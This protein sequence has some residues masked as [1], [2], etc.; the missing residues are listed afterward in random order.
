MYIVLTTL[1]YM[2]MYTC[3]AIGSCN[4]NNIPLYAPS[5]SY[6]YPG[7]ATNFVEVGQWPWWKQTLKYISACAL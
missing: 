1:A 2:Y 3:V 6:M 4:N 5:L 7:H